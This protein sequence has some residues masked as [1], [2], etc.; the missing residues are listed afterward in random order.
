MMAFQGIELP[1]FCMSSLQ[2]IAWQ[3]ANA[4]EFTQQTF[5]CLICAIFCT[6]DAVVNRTGKDPCYSVANLLEGGQCLSWMGVKASSGGD[7][8]DLNARDIGFLNMVIRK[9]FT[10]K[11]TP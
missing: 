2:D 11:V 7:C 4:P 3:M 10:E 6:E 9:V 8:W 1:C 5:E